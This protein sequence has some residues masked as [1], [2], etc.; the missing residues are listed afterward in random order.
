MGKIFRGLSASS[1]KVAGKDWIKIFALLLLLFIPFIVAICYFVPAYNAIFGTDYKCIISSATGRAYSV[2]CI[3]GDGLPVYN[4]PL[5][6]KVEWIILVI[7]YVIAG[8]FL[9][10]KIFYKSGKKKI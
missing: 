8:Y 3:D 10:R 6:Y 4:F 5:V 7:L 9:T 2:K 1:H